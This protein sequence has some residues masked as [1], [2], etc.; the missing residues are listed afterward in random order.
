MFIRLLFV[1]MFVGPPGPPSTCTCAA[2][3]TQ[4]PSQTR[5]GEA[6]RRVS[7]QHGPLG[8]EPGCPA[9]NPRPPLDFFNATD[10]PTDLAWDAALTLFFAVVADTLAISVQSCSEI[11]TLPPHVPRF[12][13]FLALRN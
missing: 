2:E 13:T 1:L 6:P 9:G 8:H 4:P 5:D 10:A 7:D 12:I 11:A 3:H